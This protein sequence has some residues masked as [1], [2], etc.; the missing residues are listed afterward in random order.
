[1]EKRICTVCGKEINVTKEKIVR[2][3]YGYFSNEGVLFEVDK[4]YRWFCENCLLEMEI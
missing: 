3:H 2:D 1:M 4:A